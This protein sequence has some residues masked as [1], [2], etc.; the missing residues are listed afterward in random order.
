MS[1]DKP[2]RTR[3]PRAKRTLA[4]VEVTEDIQTKQPCFA[5]LNS[6]PLGDNIVT[7]RLIE[8]ACRKAVYNDGVRSYG[9]RKL[10]VVAVL[11][12]FDIPFVERMALTP[13]PP[14]PPV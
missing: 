13:P 5:V 2:K 6:P 14:S 9:N 10:A 12:T 8:D 7:P 3:K 1:Q 11:S 4:L